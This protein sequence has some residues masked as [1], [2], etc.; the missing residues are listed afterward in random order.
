MSA[1][2]GARQTAIVSGGR[3]KVHSILPDG[4]EMMEEFEL[5]TDQL[6][7]RKRRGKTVLGRELE[8][9]Y[10]V[11]AAPA[12][13]TIANDTM[14]ESGANPVLCR[15]DRVDCFEWRVRN[16]PYAK[17]NYS[18]TLE[19]SDRKIVV[20]TVNK[21]YYKRIAIEDMDRLG[22]PLDECALHWE[23]DNSTLVVQYRKPA[24]LIAAE[25]QAAVAR[26]KLGDASLGD[27]SGATALAAG[28][29]GGDP[30][31]CPQQ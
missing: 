7:V 10:E 17:P 3:R 30:V 28:K 8:W 19:Q 4:S 23:H 12:R 11:G 20:R 31:Q 27:S 24:E 6:V 9:A 15:L 13:L 5:Q 18:V 16:L 22:L 29:G 21:K 2:P 14:R 1:P 26:H 25:R